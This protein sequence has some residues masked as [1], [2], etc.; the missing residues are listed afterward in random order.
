MAWRE[1]GRV[2]QSVPIPCI[3]N[4][5]QSLALKFALKDLASLR[6]KRSRFLLLPWYAD[7]I[8]TLHSGE[9]IDN[10]TGYR[11]LVGS[12]QYRSLE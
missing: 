7:S 9:L 11:A 4:L 6:Q 12:L 8:L 2:G 5:F 3:R 10:P 1:R